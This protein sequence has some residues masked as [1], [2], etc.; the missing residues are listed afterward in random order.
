MGA[1]FCVKVPWVGSFV[2]LVTTSFLLLLVRHLLLLAWHLLL[3]IFSRPGEDFEKEER[4]ERNKGIATNGARTLL[5]APGIATRSKNGTSCFVP[6]V[7]S[8][9]SCFFECGL[10]WRAQWCLSCSW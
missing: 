6:I 4:Y 5:G 8:L 2:A 10:S 3:H 9:F 7:V 1:R